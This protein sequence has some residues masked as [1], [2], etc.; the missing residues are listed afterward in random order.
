MT[1]VKWFYEDIMS[2][3]VE[4]AER[5]IPSLYVNLSC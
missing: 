5:L 4:A 2:P 1:Y 3:F